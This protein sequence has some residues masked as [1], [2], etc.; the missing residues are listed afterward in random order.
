MMMMMIVVLEVMAKCAWRIT[1]PFVYFDL[2]IYWAAFRRMQLRSLLEFQ[3]YLDLAPWLERLQKMLPN[4]ELPEVASNIGK[5][6]IT[7]QK[8]RVFFVPWQTE[9]GYLALSRAILSTMKLSIS[10]NTYQCIYGCRPCFAGLIWNW[11]FRFVFFMCSKL[12]V[13]CCCVTLSQVWQVKALVFEA[14]L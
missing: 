12:N 1:R 9:L 13:N 11:H 8:V 3:T 2:P 6:P 4:S 5:Q 7:W 14:W 10:I